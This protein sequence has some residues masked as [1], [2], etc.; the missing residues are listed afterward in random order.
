MNKMMADRIFYLHLH[1][2]GKQVTFEKNQFYEV[3]LSG[4][5]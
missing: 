4:I 1:C 5:S 2:T 3:S